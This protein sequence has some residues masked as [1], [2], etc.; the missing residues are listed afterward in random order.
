MQPPKIKRLSRED[1]KEAPAWIDRLLYWLNVLIEY[2]TL[3]FNKNITF[4][5]NI[6]SQI[7]T[8]SLTA[9]AA[10]SNN[11]IQFMATMAVVPRGLILMR[12]VDQV[13]NYTPVG[14]AVGIDWRYE[15][16][17]IFITSISGLTSGHVYDVTVL[18]I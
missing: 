13:G 17:N 4:D 5:E 7:K 9:G 18:L 16:G 14:A 3:A 15:A 6:Q 2:V 10:A 11:T 8:F 1:F 12:V